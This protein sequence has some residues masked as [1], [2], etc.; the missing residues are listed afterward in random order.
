[1][2]KFAA[3]ATA[4]SALVFGLV[5]GI[6]NSF[7]DAPDPGTIFIKKLTYGGTGCPAGTAAV[8]LSTDATAF[9]LIF[10]NFLAQKGP[11]IPLAESRKNCQVNLLLHVP[12]GFPYAVAS[13]DYRGYAD[14]AAGAKGMQKSTYYFQG[15]APTASAWTTWTGPYANNWQTRDEVATASLVWAPCGVE[16]SVNINAQ[17]QLQPGS[18]SASSQSIM[19]MDSEDGQFTTIYHLVWQHCSNP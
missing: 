16:R 11:G 2:K 4:A 10:D 19:S 7:A 5:L 8:N 17:L 9:T 1:M 3:I 12:A 6:G 15:Q 18:S 13:V 14:L